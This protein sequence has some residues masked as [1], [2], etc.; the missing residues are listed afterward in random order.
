[1]SETLTTSF[2]CEINCTA[3]HHISKLVVNKHGKKTSSTRTEKKSKRFDFTFDSEDDRNHTKFLE[4]LLASQFSERVTISRKTFFPFK[5]VVPPDT[6]K[7]AVDIDTE[8]DFK[9]MLT[10]I[11]ERKPTKL[12]S[13]TFDTAKVEKLM[14]KAKKQ[15]GDTQGDEGAVAVGSDS[16]DSD[17]VENNLL[18]AEERR[19]AEVRQELIKQWG[20]DNDNSLLYICK[21]T[22]EKVPITPFRA[23]EWIRAIVD[24]KT[25]VF[26]PPSTASFDPATRMPSLPRGRSNSHDLFSGVNTLLANI[27][28]LTNPNR[29]SPT[30]PSATAPT[31]PSEP[32]SPPINSPSKLPRFLDYVREK[33]GVD[34]PADVEALMKSKKYGPDVL[35]DIADDKLVALGLAEGDVIRMKRFAPEWWNSPNAK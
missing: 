16:D 5:A 9:K 25:T 1:M 24:K 19:F 3:S 10:R 28:N 8:K 21:I 35:K 18:S 30:T 27:A 6:Q 23:N 7:D 22:G 32:T 34:C 29:P 15:L 11:L 4:E 20:N 14:K 26:E 2:E 33:H 31:L 17:L 12:I 13:V